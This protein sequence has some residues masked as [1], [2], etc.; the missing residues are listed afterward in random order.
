MSRKSSR[1]DLV[2]LGANASPE[3]I[4]DRLLRVLRDVDTEPIQRVTIEAGGQ[5]IRVLRAPSSDEDVDAEMLVSDV[6]ASVRLNEIDDSAP[7][8]D[9]LVRCLEV[10]EENG[11]VPVCWVAGVHLDRVREGIG[12]PRRLSFKT[13]QTS[14]LLGH[15]FLQV[16]TFPDDTIVLLGRPSDVDVDVTD[17]RVGIRV[18]LE[19]FE[20]DPA[21]ALDAFATPR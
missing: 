18:S 3:D 17:A 10:L 13:T 11:F 2:P 21:S 8:I 1:L 6:L 20:T 19:G 12:R 15:P 5:P 4:C 9:T 14:F 16:S 7:S